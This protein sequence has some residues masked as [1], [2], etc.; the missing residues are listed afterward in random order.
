MT[1]Q[2]HLEPKLKRLRLSGI[3]ETLE[4][5]TNQAIDGKIA[6]TDFLERLLEDEIERREQKQLRSA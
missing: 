4:D 1:L 3:L 5:R 2:H 6:Y